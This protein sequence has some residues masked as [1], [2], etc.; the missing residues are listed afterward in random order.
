[1]LSIGLLVTTLALACAVYALVAAPVARLPIGRRVRADEA[2][3][4]LL[5]QVSAG[6]TGFVERQVK[7][8][9]WVPFS[10]REIELAGLTASQSSVLVTVGALS[11]AGGVFGL[12]I[13]NS[14]LV[15]LMLAAIVPVGAKV[16]LK[17]RTSRRRATFAGQLDSSLQML[18]AAL[19][20]GHSF[21]RAI[22]AVSR[23]TPPP[24]SEEMARIVN[25]SRLGRD[26]VEAMHDTAAR[27]KSDDFKW[28]ADA[29]AIQRDTGG[30]LSEILDRVGGTIRERNEIRAQIHALSAEGRIS[31][32]VLMALPVVVGAVYSAINPAY[33]APLFVT[34]GGRLMLGVSAVLYVVA[35]LWLRALVKVKF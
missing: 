19:R 35:A 31:A 25:E 1:M 4:S 7:T 22:D 9:G 29:V 2:E 8:R 28:V 12:I 17:L 27:L 18:S 24:M 34:V 10:S 13:G 23:E 20:A 3:R 6:L 16:M 32:I 15:A 26:I 14:V 21:S 5:S 33:M 11:F 30:N